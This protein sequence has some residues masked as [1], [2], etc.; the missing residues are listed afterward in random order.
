MCNFWN[1]YQWQSFMPKYG[2]L[3]NRPVSAWNSGQWPRWFS[4][5]ASRP[6]GLLF[7]SVAISLGLYLLSSVTQPRANTI[8]VTWSPLP[9]VPSRLEEHY[10]Y[11]IEIRKSG[12]PWSEEDFAQTFQHQAGV[13]EYSET[14][15]MR[16]DLE[17]AYV[18]RLIGKRVHKDLE[19]R[20]PLSREHEIQIT[21]TGLHTGRYV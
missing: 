3:E 21:C 17:S 8:T 14:I 16:L 19:D 9:S 15:S 1:F 2:K 20:R 4:S 12:D 10:F 6:M 11:I 18:V 13:T 7:I 5:R